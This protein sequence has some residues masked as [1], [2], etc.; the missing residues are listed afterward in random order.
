MI[1]Y[2]FSKI[3][4]GLQIIGKRDDGFHNLETIFYPVE[5]QDALEIVESKKFHF[6]TNRPEMGSFDNNLVVKAYHLLK[7]DYNLPPVDIFLYK[8]IPAGAGL[9]GGSSDASHTILM[10]D[11]LFCLGMNTEKKNKYALSLGSDCPFFLENKPVFATG[12]GEITEEISIRLNK[13]N[14]ILVSPN[15]SIS[16]KEAY[17]HISVKKEKYSLK[18]IIQLPPEKWKEKITNNF[19]EYVFSKYPETSK[20][21]NTLYEHGAC[22]S[23]MSGSGSSVYGI[24]KKKQENIESWFPKNYNIFQQNL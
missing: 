4:I 13:Y 10:L 14:I 7:K 23:L 11:K 21:K 2:P 16:T 12:R 5:L 15:T 17:C 22:F 8:R 19:E 20:I 6:G 24:F 9:G 1:T 18:E 3:N